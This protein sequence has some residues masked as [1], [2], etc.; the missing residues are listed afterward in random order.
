[1]GY[2]DEK[3]ARNVHQLDQ[4][5]WSEFQQ[6]SS[7]ESNMNF[8]PSCLTSLFSTELTLYDRNSIEPTAWL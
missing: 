5:T 1:M 8:F 7:L 2:E 6:V 4:I 3:T